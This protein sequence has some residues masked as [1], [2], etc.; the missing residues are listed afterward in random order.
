MRLNFINTQQ[1][2]WAAIVVGGASLAVG[3]YQSAKGASNQKKAEKRSEELFK[4][5]KQYETPAEILD[6]FNQA[7]YN[8]QTGFSNTTL[9][10][11][12]SQANGALAGS[13][14][15]AK[16]LGADPNSI[17]GLLDQS[18]QNIFK[19]GSE[20]DMLKMKK[21][22]N[23]LNATQ[24]VAQGK[25][26]E[27]VSGQ[28]LIKD[29]MAVQFQKGQ[30]AQIDRQSGLNLIINGASAVAT[31]GLFKTD[32]PKPYKSAYTTKQ[33]AAYDN[34]ATP[35]ASNVIG[36][37]PRDLNYEIKAPTGGPGSIFG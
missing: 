5:R 15:T 28:N 9:S 16:Q 1:R 21:F 33:N 3:A 36:I 14:D 32:T 20:N 35:S 2:T 29:Q 27:Y 17:S 12:T 6:I 10:Y 23:L 13:L 31:S 22:D 11:L 8:A 25:D 34:S 26:A 37:L 24:M 19:I 7:Q 4:N 30:Q 18:F